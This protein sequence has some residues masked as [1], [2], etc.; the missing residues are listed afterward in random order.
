[1]FKN[2]FASLISRENLTQTKA[3]KLLGQSPQTIHKWLKGMVDPGIDDLIKISKE[4]NVSIDTLLGNPRFS[5]SDGWINIPVLDEIPNDD[6]R[7]RADLHTT[8]I[9]M[10]SDLASTFDFGYLVQ[11]KSMEFAGI[12][13]LDIVFIQYEAPIENGQIYLT[14]INKKATI[15]R[16][17]VEPEFYVLKREYNQYKP[18]LVNRENP[19]GFR[20]V[21]KVVG[22]FRPDP[23]PYEDPD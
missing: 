16:I 3:G 2:V 21:G 17:F 9:P 23:I 8:S 22:L 14:T 19:A 11:N 1:M 5:N 4:F 13:L 10:S 20:L 12:W 7:Q 18:I 15:A 6:P